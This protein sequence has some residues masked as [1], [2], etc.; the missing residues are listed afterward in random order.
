MLIV[1]PTKTLIVNTETVEGI[2]VDVKTSFITASSGDS[3]WPLGKYD[4]PEKIMQQILNA[5]TN[6]EKVFFMPYE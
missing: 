6:N 2:Y 3:L 5:Y 1:A 4:N